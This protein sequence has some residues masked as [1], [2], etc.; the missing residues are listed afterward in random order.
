MGINVCATITQLQRGLLDVLRVKA[1]TIPGALAHVRPGEPM[2]MDRKNKKDQQREQREKEAGGGGGTPTGADSGKNRLSL[3]L[4]SS[5]DNSGEGSFASP[6]PIRSALSSSIQSPPTSSASQRHSSS[7]MREPFGPP[8]AGLG[9]SPAGFGRSPIAAF[10]SSPSRPSPLSA[11]FSG[12]PSVPG[13]LALKNGTGAVTNH[14][15]LRPP[16]SAQSAGFSS[17]FSHAI[18]PTDHRAAAPPLSASLADGGSHI[19]NI[20]A[21]SDSAAEPLSPRRP[22]L[23]HPRQSNEMVFLDDDN[24]DDHGED[25]LPASLND[26]LTPAERA[27]RLSRRDSND[28]HGVSPA[29]GGFLSAKWTTT[30]GAG[31]ER[32]AQSAGAN[33]GPANFLQSLW[34]NDG[35]D[36]RRG[37]ESPYSAGLPRPTAGPSPATATAA[38]GAG[39]GAWAAGAPRQSLLS[40]Q[41]TPATATGTSPGRSVES[42]NFLLRHPPHP[43]SPSARAFQEHA[44]GQSLPGGVATALSRLHLHAPGPSGLAPSPMPADSDKREPTPPMSTVP[45]PTKRADDHDEGLFAMDG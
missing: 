10:S 35:A 30:P 12:R 1:L 15:P 4:G 9:G 45:L 28:S 43:S 44:P 38:G 22:I 42:N 8:S 27:R 23:Q 41:R 25:F 34:S 37:D 7:P 36:K 26:L 16:T 21:R 6:V 5:L 24:D 20:W 29:R 13:P 19:K 2:S 3:P 17:S 39:G 32:L 33:L 11:S 18:V 31:P 40:Q 14:S